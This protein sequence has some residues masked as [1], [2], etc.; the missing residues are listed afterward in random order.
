VSAQAGGRQG[1]S[2]Q[3]GFLDVFNGTAFLPSLCLPAG[4]SARSATLREKAV[5]LAHFGSFRQIIDDSG[6]A[7]F[8]RF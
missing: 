4:R 1:A 5:L 2:R 7:F 3:M 8:E 6:N